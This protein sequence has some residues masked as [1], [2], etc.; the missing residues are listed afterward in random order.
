MPDKKKKDM[1]ILRIKYAAY[2]RELL[3]EGNDLSNVLSFK[4]WLKKRN[5]KSE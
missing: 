3:A 2:R 5:D 4:E 1:N